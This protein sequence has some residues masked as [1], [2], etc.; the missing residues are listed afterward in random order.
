MFQKWSV[1]SAHDFLTSLLTTPTRPPYTASMGTRFGAPRI[2]FD[3]RSFITPAVKILVLTCAG[4]FL[5][6]TLIE[7]F[8][9]PVAVYRQITMRFGLVPSGVV[10]GLRIW[11]PVT[12]LF[13]HHDIWHLLINMLMLWM[14][15]RELELVWGKNRFINYFFLCGIGAGLITV[16]VK[17]LPMF[18]G[19][20]ASDI[21]TIGASGAIFGILIANAILFPDRQIWL[22][23]LPIMIPMRP[24]VAVMAAIEF[25]ATLSSSAD[26][27]SHFC[28]LGGMLVGWLYLRRGSFLFRVRNEMAD[29]RY[30]RNRKKFEVFMKKNK[31]ASP[32]DPDH[33]VN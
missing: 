15:G 10:P 26:G 6:Q 9:G 25:F 27:V 17:C 1:L 2:R 23:P 8:F 4:I 20:P 5:L 14:F 12:Y 19:R 18:W 30:E 24:F 22:F 13:L 11:Q 7:I 3:W 29:W 21:P 16:L 33:W 31:D 32:S 28:H